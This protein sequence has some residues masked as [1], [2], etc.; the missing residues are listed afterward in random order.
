MKPCGS[1]GVRTF[2]WRSALLNSRQVVR[3]GGELGCNWDP[4]PTVPQAAKPLPSC[5]QF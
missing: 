5:L 4:L 1:G 3:E 2:F